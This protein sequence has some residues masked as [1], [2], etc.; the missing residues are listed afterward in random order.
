MFF[1]FMKLP[2]INAAGADEPLYVPRQFLRP[3]RANTRAPTPL[4]HCNRDV[5]A[6]KGVIPCLYET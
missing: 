3:D 4:L 6:L 5:F 1:G 2:L